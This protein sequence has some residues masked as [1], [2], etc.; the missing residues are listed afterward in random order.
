MSKTIRFLPFLLLPLV[1]SCRSSIEEEGDRL[2]ESGKYQEAIQQYDLAIKKDSS[3]P[4]LYFKRGKAKYIYYDRD[5]S[6]KDISGAIAEM[7]DSSFLYYWRGLAFLSPYR[8]NDNMNALLDFDHALSLKP[9]DPK[10]YKARGQANYELRNYHEAVRDFS[11][12]IEMDSSDGECWLNRGHSRLKLLAYDDAIADYSKAI[13]LQSDDPDRYIARGNARFKTSDFFGAVVDY[14]SAIQ[15]SQSRARLLLGANAGERIWLARGE[16]WEQR[17]RYHNAATLLLRAN[18]EQRIW[19]ARGGSY[20]RRC[21]QDDYLGARS[22]DS[23]LADVVEVGLQSI[24]G[25]FA[26]GRPELNLERNRFVQ[27]VSS[28]TSHAEVYFAM[29]K[30][31][32]ILKKY[33]VAKEKLSKAISKNPELASAYA[34][35]GNAEVGLGEYIQAVSDYTKAMT[36]DPND[37]QAFLGRAR[38]KRVLKDLRG[39][40][41]DYTAAIKRDSTVAEALL[42]RGL[43][44]IELGQKDSGCL[45]L[46]RAGELGNP[47]AYKLIKEHCMK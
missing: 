28:D 43:T 26:E 31:Y 7:P 35:R 19:S 13:A 45:D 33:T 12:S 10:L 46:S 8:P 29:G 38:A 1:I 47:T 6:I 41:E 25:L 36:L 40:I 21:A 22:G 20:W 5:G 11:K 14:S 23:T 18:A 9:H 2:F 4:W 30:V 37:P 39:A 44:R 32:R 24:E 27:V 15:L 42:G 17:A 34:E 3:N 16:W